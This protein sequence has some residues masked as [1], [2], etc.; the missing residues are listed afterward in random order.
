[1]LA[2][3]EFEPHPLLRNP[4]LMTVAATLWPRERRGLPPA[5]V[6]WFEVEPGTQIL[7]HCHWQLRPAEGPTLVLVHGLEGSSDSPYMVGTAAL[8]FAAGCNVVRL[9][10]RNCG[11]TDHL[12]PTL[13]HSG[14]SADLAAVVVELLER[15]RL[16]A[17]CLA[18]FSMGGNLVLKMAGEFGAQPPRGLCGVAGV[19][20]ALELAPCVAAIERPENALYHWHFLRQLKRR[21][22]RKA[23][24]FPHLYRVD[25]LHSIRSIREFDDRITA[26]HS[27]F[28]SAADYYH[29]ASAAR[30][31]AQIRL[32]TLILTARDDTLVPFSIFA[33]AGVENN[34][35]I[36]LVAPEHG[37]HCAFVS[38]HRGDERFWAEARLVEFC[39]QQSAKRMFE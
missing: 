33:A 15:D 21:M 2:V 19:C 3:R 26:P 23:R 13:Y 25:G 32:P 9:N 8:A 7:A 24:L 34:S 6:R 36:T 14:R 17:V 1:M 12:T 29:R 10:Q 28:L 11:G 16:P 4:H 20:P 35:W 31:I 5:Q 39:R 27:G 37:G 30:V 22:E 18:G 38:R